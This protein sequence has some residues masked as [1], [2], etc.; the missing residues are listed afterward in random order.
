MPLGRGFS[1]ARADCGYRAPLAPRLARSNLIVSPAESGGGETDSFFRSS[2][3]SPAAKAFNSRINKAQTDNP[4]VRVLIVD[5]QDLFRTG[6]ASLLKAQH[7]IEVVGQ[8]S[9]G[10]LG[11]RLANELRP[12]VVLMDLRPPDIAGGEAIHAIVATHPSMRALVLTAAS[13][14]AAVATAMRAGASG[15]LAKDTPVDEV[16]AAVRATARGVAWLS[17]RA[18]E[19]VLGRFVTRT[20]SQDPSAPRSISCRPVSGMCC[21]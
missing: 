18:A 6:L 15:F 13:E 14:D 19:I 11:V 21:A 2:L 5:D 3:V 7:D 12:D 4:L 20:S 10:R 1:P 17:P 8:A 16:V 9:G